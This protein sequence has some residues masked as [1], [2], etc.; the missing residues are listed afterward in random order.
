MQRE[1]IWS[2]RVLGEPYHS[3]HGPVFPVESD[4][5]FDRNKP[6][7]VGWPVMLAGERYT[8]RAV[9][10]HMPA[11]PIRKGETIGLLV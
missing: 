8:V 10:R 2:P 7:C 5:E 6:E 9:E 11:F 4:R 3:P 1:A